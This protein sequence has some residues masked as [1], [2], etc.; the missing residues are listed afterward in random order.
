MRV[1]KF[2]SILSVVI[3]VLFI[4]LTSSTFLLVI[5]APGMKV[6]ASDVEQYYDPVVIVSLG[7]SYS[8]GEG[9]EPFY[10]QDKPILEKMENKDWLAHRSRDSWP[11]KL[12]VPG[13]DGSA[14]NYRVTGT[15][16]GTNPME[17]YFAAVSGAESK[18]IYELCQLKTSII[19]SGMNYNANYFYNKTETYFPL[20]LDVFDNIDKPVDYVTLTIGGNDAGFVDIITTAMTEPSGLWGD[21]DLADKLASIDMDS[22]ISKLK[23]TYNKIE[24]AAGGQAAILVGGYPKLLHSTFLL[25]SESE[26]TLVNN[27]VSMFNDK[28]ED[29][30]E[31]CAADGMNIHFVDIE[32]EFDNNGGHEAY[33]SD[34]W[35]NKVYLGHKEQDIDWTSPVSS[36]S[37]HPNSAGT[38]AYARCFNAKIAELEEE[39]LQTGT[40][41]GQ[42]CKASDRLA[43][44]T[45]ATIQLYK[46]GEEFRSFQ[47]NSDGSYNLT[48]PVGEYRIVIESPGFIEFEA[49]AVVTEGS[50]FYMET[51]LLVAGEEGETGTA[52]G[53]ITSALSG[54]GV[55]DVSLTVRD[56]WYNTSHGGIITTTSTNS[57]GY[58][59]LSL[60]IGNYTLC[61][62]KDG[63]IST[64][65]NVIVQKEDSGPQNGSI[66]PNLT[67]NEYRIVLEW[68]AEPSDL[69]SHVEGTLIDGTGFHVY[70]SHK[71]QMDG[72][73][74]V[75]NLDVDDVTGYGPETITLQI[76]NDDNP[77]YF[78]VFNYSG[79]FG[80]DTALDYSAANV[81]VFKG[82]ELLAEYNVLP[83][84]MGVGLYW[85]VFAINN[86][87][88][89]LNNTISDSADISYA[90]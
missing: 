27:S 7:D 64:S 17:W 77:Y 79:Q 13:I 85:N 41:S 19:Y 1:K 23:T 71:S 81:K 58:Y 55:S 47:A 33:S 88:I 74:E 6:L 42:I 51:F 66:T 40:L 49:Y 56:G 80:Y 63:Y 43:P 12:K 65:M 14:I 84:I 21:V 22:L 61:A 45:N 5:P 78:Y 89:I 87:E 34:P 50:N 83:N 10:G 18:H 60:P 76:T 15:P 28:I 31:E 68:A 70:Y 2:K 69:D 3:A 8:A 36:Y 20:Q 44:V 86:G 11:A 37:M 32:T 67:G 75:C 46:D 26:A 54:S 38:D 72:E 25:V 90:D 24:E 62:E 59:S 9:N 53:S 16:G 39:G 57:I 35:I 30:V 29:L 52:Y 4:F 48:L 73:F 82:T